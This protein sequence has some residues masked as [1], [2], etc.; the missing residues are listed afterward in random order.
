MANKHPLRGFATV[1]YYAADHAAAIEWYT[2][3]AGI[4]PYFS[5]P[6]YAEFRI[7]DYQHEPGIIDAQY[8]PKGSAT[9]PGGEVIYWHV[10]N[11]EE[12]L[13]RL[14]EPGATAYEPIIQRGAGFVTASVPDPFGK[15][16]IINISNP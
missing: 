1:N 8:K 12:A 11:I 13:D 9:T 6:G 4:P 5:K 2:E 15:Q 16:L 3:V 10:D 7:G 14:P